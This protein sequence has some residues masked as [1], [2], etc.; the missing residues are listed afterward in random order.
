MVAVS[1]RK[2]ESGRPIQSP[3]VWCSSK[4]AVGFSTIPTEQ[5]AVACML[6]GP[7]RRTLF[8]LT[9]KGTKPE[10][11]AGAGTGR[12]ETVRVEVPGAGLP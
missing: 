7:D 11:V 2:A 12:I 6:G 5:S 3:A 4:R 1:M 9:S 8:I 10:R